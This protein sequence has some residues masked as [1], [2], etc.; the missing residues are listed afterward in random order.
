MKW[1]QTKWYLSSSLWLCGLY[2][3]PRGKKDQLN[4]KNEKYIFV[5]YS[6][7][8]MEYKLFNPITKKGI[9][10]KDVIFEEDKTLKY[11]KKK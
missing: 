2:K 4:D 3:D 1:S 6:D 8:R 11:I 9:M 7:R 5:R 10:S